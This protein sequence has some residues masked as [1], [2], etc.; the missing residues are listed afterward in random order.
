MQIKLYENHQ[1]VLCAMV[2]LGLRLRVLPVMPCCFVYYRPLYCYHTTTTI[3]ITTKLGEPVGIY[4]NI[5]HTRFRVDSAQY[6]EVT[7][8][9]GR[10][11]TQTPSPPLLHFSNHYSLLSYKSHLSLDPCIS[12]RTNLVSHKD[13]LWLVTTRTYGS[14]STV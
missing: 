4:Y 3:H 10:S 2:V 1:C 8:S 11:P 12:L 7:L 5:L 6:G 14:M 13:E 9:Q